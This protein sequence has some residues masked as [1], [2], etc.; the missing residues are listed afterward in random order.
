MHPVVARTLRMV[1]NIGPETHKRCAHRADEELALVSDRLSDGRHYLYTT[2]PA[3]GPQA[4]GCRAGRSLPQ[5]P[6]PA[7]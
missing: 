6:A 7:N 5:G 3:K 4:Q 1:F 2:V